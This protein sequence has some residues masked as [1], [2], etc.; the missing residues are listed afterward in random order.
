[1][2]QTTL[3]EVVEHI[4]SDRPISSFGKRLPVGMEIIEDIREGSENVNCFGVRV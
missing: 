3:H 2:E 4:R 1:M